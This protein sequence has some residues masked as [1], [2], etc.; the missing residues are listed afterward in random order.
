MTSKHPGAIFRGNP[1]TNEAGRF[2]LAMRRWRER[3][4]EWERGGCKGSRPVRPTRPDP[5]ED[6]ALGKPRE[7]VESKDERKRR[8]KLEH[9][10]NQGRLF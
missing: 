10:R 1:N 2:E 3:L 5:L 9:Q 7:E 6:S 4:A 8:L